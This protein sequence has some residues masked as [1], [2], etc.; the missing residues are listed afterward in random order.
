MLES[1]LTAAALAIALS[2]C[3]IAP[4]TVTP[5]VTHMSH[6]SQHEPFTDRPTSYG[7]NI[8]DVSVG[9]ELSRHVTL[10]LAE[11]INLNRH[12]PSSDEYGDI[13]GPRE[14]FTARLGYAFRVRK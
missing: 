13:K 14:E 2:G 3:A 10:T 7:A 8:A 1:K 6:A 9:W 4:N 12:Y 5:E 11:G